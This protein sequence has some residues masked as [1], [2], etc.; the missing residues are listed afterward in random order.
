MTVYRRY[1][2]PG[3]SYVFDEQQGDAHEGFAPG[4][5][6]EMVPEDWACPDCAVREKPDFEELPAADG[7]S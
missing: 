4:T 7:G 3:C 2:C 1:R 6:W 5:R